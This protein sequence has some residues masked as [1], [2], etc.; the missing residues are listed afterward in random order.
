MD[1]SATIPRQSVVPWDEMAVGIRGLALHD[2]KIVRPRHSSAN[3]AHIY[4]VVP[5][6]TAFASTARRNSTAWFCRVGRTIP[7]LHAPY[8][9]RR[10]NVRKY[11]QLRSVLR[12]MSSCYAHVRS[13]PM[14]S[15]DVN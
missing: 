3:G 8:F 11:V 13:G 1:D 12:E 5:A 10:T 9:R 15:L 6:D 14:A 4:L 7:A 2:E